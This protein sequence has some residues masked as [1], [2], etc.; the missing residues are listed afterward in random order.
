MYYISFIL[1]IEWFLSNLIIC[2]QYLAFPHYKATLGNVF[3]ANQEGQDL[4]YRASPKAGLVFEQ[5][6]TYQKSDEE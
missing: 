6:F 2:P 4:A 1:L 5:F 3:P